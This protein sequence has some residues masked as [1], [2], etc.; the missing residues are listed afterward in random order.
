M[1]VIRSKIK[2]CECVGNFNDE[3]VYDIGVHHDTNQWVFA[4]NILVHNSCYMSIDTKSFRKKYPDFDY[5]KNN[6]VKFAD[7]VGD[8]INESFP[9]FMEKTFHCQNDYKNI[10]KAGR[11]TVCSKGLFCGKKRYALMVFDKDGYRKDINGEPGYLKIMG[12]QVSRSDTPKIVR[13]LLKRL[14]KSILTDGSKEKLIEILREFGENEWKKLNPW[15]KGT[16]KTVNK[17]TIKTDELKTNYKALVPGH[18]MASI[19]WN[20]MID[21]AK[22]RKSPKI[23]DGDKVI[24]CKLKNNIYNF[25]SIAIPNTITKI[26]K[27]FKDLPFDEQSMEDSIV[28]RTI[29]T[30]FGVI[31]WNLKL[32]DAMNNN[33]NY[34]DGIIQFN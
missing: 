4:N 24:V 31:G 17:L 29:E 10:M 11:E 16:P 26:P 15:E 13:N 21:I 2:R 7:Y 19:N 22:D 18:V 12:I 34:L 32:S 25:K 14:L 9:E 3:Y 28:D 5:S 1:K 23:M 20:R 27:W 8:K 33:E 30:V 6:L